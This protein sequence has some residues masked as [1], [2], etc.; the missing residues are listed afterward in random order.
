MRSP[1]TCLDA[2]AEVEQV[3]AGCC[4]DTL[5]D[6]AARLEPAMVLL[7]RRLS[8]GQL[9][10]ALRQLVEALLPDGSDGDDSDPYFFEL[11]A[12]LDGDVDVSGHLDPETG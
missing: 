4:A 11:R 7:A 12:L 10:P 6:P 8:P 1:P 3:L 9:G 5:S 2:R